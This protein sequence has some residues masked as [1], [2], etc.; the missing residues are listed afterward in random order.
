[1]YS[2]EGK[3]KE[4]IRNIGVTGKNRDLVLPSYSYRPGQLTYS[5]AVL[6]D[7]LPF[8]SRAVKQLTKKPPV[9]I[10]VTAGRKALNTAIPEHG[11]QRDLIAGCPALLSFCMHR[12]AKHIFSSLKVFCCSVVFPKFYNLPLHTA[13]NCISCTAGGSRSQFSKENVFSI[14]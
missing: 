4:Q 7:V 1:M 8:I 11:R 10:L 3:K 14:Q 9:F 5:E 6:R 13:H 12:T 2:K